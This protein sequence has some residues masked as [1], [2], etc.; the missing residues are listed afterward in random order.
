LD[1][2]MVGE[3]YKSRDQK[4]KGTETA[5]LD[6][7]WRS[8]FELIEYLESQCLLG[9]NHTPALT[10]KKLISKKAKSGTQFEINRFL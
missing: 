10:D 1:E 6:A 2:P 3:A 9:S 8:N 4:V 7:P 5:P